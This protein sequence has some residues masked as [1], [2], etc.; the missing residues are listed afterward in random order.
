[1][2]A[3]AIPNATNVLALFSNA[4]TVTNDAFWNYL[5]VI[6]FVIFFLLMKTFT[7]ERAVVVAAFV[8]ALASFFFGIAGLVDSSLILVFTMLMILGLIFS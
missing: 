6:L 3:F 4:N 1:M 8:C 2:M 5:M 7:A